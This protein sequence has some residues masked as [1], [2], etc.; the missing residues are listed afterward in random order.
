MR[1]AI[2]FTILVC[3]CAAQTTS[4]EGE[5]VSSERIIADR[6]HLVVRLEGTSPRDAETA[7]V[8]FD[9]AFRFNRIPTG[10][11]VLRVVDAHGDEI[12]SQPITVNTTNMP[13]SLKL[14]DIAG[15][16]PSGERI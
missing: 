2:V 6:S 15:A 11:Y 8:S 4:L 7:F 1:A 5:L 10:S 3:A 9:G 16:R 12:L 13:V 14:P